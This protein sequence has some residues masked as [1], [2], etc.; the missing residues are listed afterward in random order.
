MLL[1][2]SVVSLAFLPRAPPHPSTPSFVCKP[3]AEVS[4]EK[5][6][7]PPNFAVRADKEF[8]LVMFINSTDRYFQDNFPELVPDPFVA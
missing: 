1:A 6:I 2:S 8:P 7:L 4:S 3:F 5:A